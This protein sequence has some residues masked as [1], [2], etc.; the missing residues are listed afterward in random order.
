MTIKDPRKIIIRPDGTLCAKK[1]N[2]IDIGTDKTNTLLA[3][4][5]STRD[6]LK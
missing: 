3:I 4:Y 6:L 5:V 2:T 1:P